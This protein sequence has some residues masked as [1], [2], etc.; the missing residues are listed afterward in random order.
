MGEIDVDKL[1]KKFKQ[2]MESNEQRRKK[3]FP[4]SD[5]LLAIVLRGHLLVEERLD[6]LNGHYF[7]FPTYYEEAKLSFH[8]KLLIAKAQVI[9][10]N[11]DFIFPVLFKLNELRN[12]LAH[13]L[14]SPKLTKKVNVFI[15]LVEKNYS[16]ENKEYLKISNASKE[17][18]T[19]YAISYIMGQLDVL[20]NL[21]EF[22]E[23]SRVYGG[24]LSK[25]KQNG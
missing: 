16:K 9:A 20:D 10:P 8:K 13:N 23:K 21:I 22:M 25:Q 1:I 3:F 24:N 14:D 11:P 17:R 18:R 6:T 5:D 7:R 4:K 2:N 15:N 12:N 19:Q